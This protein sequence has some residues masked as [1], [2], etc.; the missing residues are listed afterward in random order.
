[1]SESH[2]AGWTSE[3]PTPAQLKELFAQIDSGKITKAKLQ[4]FLRGQP[5][6]L[7]SLFTVLVPVLKGFSVSDEFENGKNDI[8]LVSDKFREYFVGS[9]KASDVAKLRVSRLCRESTNANILKELGD[10][11]E[12][13]LAH[14]L[15]ALSIKKVMLL[16]N[17]Y[18]NIFY[19]RDNEGELRV[20]SLV[21]GQVCGW[22]LEVG[23]IEDGSRWGRDRRVISLD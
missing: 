16:A 17:G 6:L 1:M 4:D 8:D 18:A 7:E 2:A 15:H 12:T 19:V 5:I 21:W 23:A 9:V 3:S 13:T 20:V 11:A 14:V 22:D 10:K